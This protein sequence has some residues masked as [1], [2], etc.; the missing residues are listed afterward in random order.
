MEKLRKKIVKYR[1]A[2][3]II[4][5][6][7]MIPSAMGYFK[8]KVNYDILYYLP[9]DIETMIGQDILM[10]EFGKGAFAMEIV[11]GMSTKDVAGIKKEI[12]AV[13]GVAEVI[14]YDTLMDISVPMEVL[15]EELKDVFNTDD[16]TL[17]AIFFD[18]TTSA[19]VR[20]MP[21]LKSAELRMTNVIS[22]VCRRWSQ[23]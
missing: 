13:N 17:M 11:E 2:I 19:T 23:I 18:D 4:G 10:D 7:L 21:L 20:W 15:P 14:W 8:T 1:V 22:V 3:L 9:D 6:L 12:E 16:A 5:F